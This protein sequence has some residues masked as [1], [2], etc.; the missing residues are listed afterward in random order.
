[1]VDV[2]KFRTLYSIFACF[3]FVFVFIYSL[4]TS[5]ILSETRYMFVKLVMQI[6]PQSLQYELQLCAFIGINLLCSS[7]GI[8]RT[9]W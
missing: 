4:L 1:M 3:F 7:R 8:E 9:I 2:L 5:A 6:K